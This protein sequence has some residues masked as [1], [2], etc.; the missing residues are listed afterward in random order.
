MSVMSAVGW[1]AAREYISQEEGQERFW[2]EAGGPGSTGLSLPEP[3]DVDLG[4]S[5]KITRLEKKNYEYF[6]HFV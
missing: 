3:G 2:R 5:R 1:K 4:A 6:R